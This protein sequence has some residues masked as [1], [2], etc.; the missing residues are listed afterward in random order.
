MKDWDG[1]NKSVYTTLGASN[2]ALGKR[3]EMDYYAT[4]PVAVEHLL[5]VERPEN[6]WEPH[7]GELHLVTQM[8]DAGINVRATDII[9]RSAP[10]D[11]VVDFMTATQWGGDIVMNP[12]YKFALGHIK[13]ALE[14]IDKGKRVFAFLKLQFLE[15]KARK[16][17]FELNPPKT[18]YVFSF[19]VP[20]FKNGRFDLY[21]S[22]AI[23][24]AWFVW[25]K[26]YT[27]ETVIKWL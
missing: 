18:I 23:A 24:Y 10:L 26:G 4:S 8:R 9:Q 2:H 5:K 12:P 17:F 13:K 20:C 1:N 6:V 7:A 16:I 14:I 11:D 19:R 22:S 21:D 3:D 27:G 15:G 25:E